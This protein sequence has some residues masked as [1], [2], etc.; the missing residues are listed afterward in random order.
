MV[1][2]RDFLSL[3][4]HHWSSGLRLSSI[5]F[6]WK[7]LSVLWYIA[8]Q[9]RERRTDIVH[10]LS[11]LFSSPFTL[12]LN[13]SSHF[14]SYNHNIYFFYL[15]WCFCVISTLLC[16]LFC[17]HPSSPLVSMS[18]LRLLFSLLISSCLISAHHLTTPSSLIFFLILSPPSI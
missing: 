10:F 17:V 3:H 13:A 7:C 15:I 8:M 16:H 9:E 6:V 12:S 11:H 4:S 14:L 5:V 2:Q 1:W 18:R